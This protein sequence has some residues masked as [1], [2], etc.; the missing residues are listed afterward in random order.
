MIRELSILIPA[1]NLCCVDLVRT[2]AG[3]VAAL[4]INYEII[5]ADDGSTS[6]EAKTAN[7]A[8]NL[9][10][11]CRY[12]ERPI[13]VGRAAIRNAL[14]RESRFSHLLFIDGDM[15]VIRPDFIEAYLRVGDNDV[16]DGGVK[17]CGDSNALSRN[18]RFRYEKAKEHLHTAERRQASPYSDF[19]TANFLVRRDIM[20]AHG[21]DERF[22]RYGYEDVAFGKEMKRHGI[23]IL[24]I[25]NPLGFSSF[26]SNKEFVG[27]TD[28]SLMTLVDFADELQ[29]FSRLL[30]LAIRLRRLHLSAFIVAFHKL[31]GSSIRR[32]LCGN[33]PRLALFN[34]YK[35]GKLFYLYK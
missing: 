4:A 2:L 8:I 29:G 35:T 32:N 12:W 19:H 10:S 31:F 9:I 18:L 6:M 5:V 1:Y 13:N 11:C 20:I 34:I 30:D 23:T 24:H 25:D 27:K 7:R 17:V 15:T 22:S 16:V 14:A 21:F 28:E 26:E 3:Q 33:N